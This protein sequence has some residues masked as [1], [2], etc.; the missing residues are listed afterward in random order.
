MTDDKA[1]KEIIETDYENAGL[2]HLPSIS[3]K[4]TSLNIKKNKLK[5]LYSKLSNLQYLNCSQNEIHE[6]PYYPNTIHINCSYNLIHSVPKELLNIEFFDGSSNKIQNMFY[7]P[8]I[9]ELFIKNNLIENLKIL[10][11]NEFLTVMDVSNNPLKDLDIKLPF[12]RELYLIKCNLTELSGDNFPSLEVLNCSENQINK[13]DN[14]TNLIELNCSKNNKIIIGNVLPNLS[15]LFAD[16]CYLTEFPKLICP[17]KL[18]TCN[19]GRNFITEVPT[20]LTGLLSLQIHHNKLNSFPFDELSKIKE[21]NISHNIIK[22][23]KI[24]R[25][26]ESLNMEFN[27]ITNIDINAY[28]LKELTM[29]YDDFKKFNL[30]NHIDIKGVDIEI[31]KKTLK[32]IFK[33]QL[34]LDNKKSEILLKC[35]VNFNFNNYEDELMNLVIRIHKTSLKQSTEEDLLKMSKTFDILNKIIHINMVVNLVTNSY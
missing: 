9:K 27:K 23:C 3:S 25:H 21:L 33:K 28:L 8:K 11:V 35:V 24:T 18:Q 14:F 10:N 17:E 1:K 22:N 2:E 29:S 20:N 16:E 30:I 32:H 5:N 12:L 31:N 19:L 26:I 34:N 7:S 15:I 6:L 4:T 13:I